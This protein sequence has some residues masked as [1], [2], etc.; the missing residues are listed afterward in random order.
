MIVGVITTKD[1]LSHP[2][3]LISMEGLL[4]YLGLVLLALSRKKYLLLSCLKRV[5]GS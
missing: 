5:E 4:G 1:V 3:T 2:A